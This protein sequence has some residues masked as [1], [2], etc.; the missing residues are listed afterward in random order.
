MKRDWIQIT[1][2][3]AIMIGLGVVIYELNQNYIHARVQL[4]N[5]DYINTQT[6]LY[7]ICGY[8]RYGSGNQR[9]KNPRHRKETDG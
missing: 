9:R 5:D 3:I 4:L 7:T 2:N 1:S 8:R 6:H